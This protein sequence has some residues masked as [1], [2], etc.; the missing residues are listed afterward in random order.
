MKQFEEVK[1]KLDT[2]LKNINIK[3][4]KAFGLYELFGEK[5]KETMKSLKDDEITGEDEDN[6]NELEE[7]NP[8]E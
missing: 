8:D 4:D 6:D 2:Y 3:I 5:D 7:D 1:N